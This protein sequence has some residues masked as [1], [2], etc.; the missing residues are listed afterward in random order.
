MNKRIYFLSIL[1]IIIFNLEV[2]G[3]WQYTT[4]HGV[5]GG[6]DSNGAIIC[7]PPYTGTVCFTLWQDVPGPGNPADPQPPG[8]YTGVALFIPTESRGLIGINGVNYFQLGN[9]IIYSPITTPETAEVT[10]ENQIIEWLN[11]KN[12]QQP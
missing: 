6:R 2:F 11:N 4:I 1:I 7:T 5:Y 10:D 9:N 12:N 8:H 3:Y